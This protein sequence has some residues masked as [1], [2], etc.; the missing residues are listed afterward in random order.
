MLQMLRSL[1]QPASAARLAMNPF[2]KNRLLPVEVMI[3]IAINI[4]AVTVGYYIV[5][6]WGLFSG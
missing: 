5:I 3:T 6:L 1:F 2:E 4:A